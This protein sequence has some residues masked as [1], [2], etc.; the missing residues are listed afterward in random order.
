MT[1]AGNE[2]SAVAIMIAATLRRY[3]LRVSTINSA[4][5]ATGPDPKQLRKLTARASAV[6][7]P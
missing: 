2:T 4:A 6:A 7:F 3:G 5:S 1:I